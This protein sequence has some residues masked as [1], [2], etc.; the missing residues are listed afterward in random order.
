MEEEG[1]VVTIP[2]YSTKHDEGVK[3]GYTAYHIVINWKGSEW[4]TAVRYSTFRQLHDAVKRRFPSIRLPK[5]PPKK[6][7]GNAS[8]EFLE[9]RRAELETYLS[10]LLSV[11]IIRASEEVSRTLELSS[12]IDV[13]TLSPPATAPA[14]AP[15]S[16][17]RV[18]APASS[19]SAEPS[20]EHSTHTSSYDTSYKR[21]VALYDFD[22]D[23]SQNQMSFYV[24][25]VLYVLSQDDPEQT[26]WWWGE[27]E[28]GT[29]GYLPCD[30]I[31][32]EA[33]P[34]AP[35]QPASVPQHEDNQE[36]LSSPSLRS[37]RGGGNNG[38]VQPSPRA[39]TPLPSPSQ[40]RLH[41]AAAVAA[42]HTAKPAGA[43]IGAVGG[44]APVNVQ[45]PRLEVGNKKPPPPVPTRGSSFPSLPAVPGAG[46]GP[47]PST[48]PA[49][50]AHKFAH[51]LG[52]A[53]PHQPHQSASPA[54]GNKAPTGPRRMPAPPQ[55]GVSQEQLANRIREVGDGRPSPPRAPLG[56]PRPYQPGLPPSGAAG[57]HPM[58]AMR[59]AIPQRPRGDASAISPAN[60]SQDGTD[61][62]AGEGHHQ[63]PAS[64]AAA[65]PQATAA[66]KSHRRTMIATEILT[67]ERTYVEGLK[68]LIDEYK[69][70]MLKLTTEPNTAITDAVIKKIFSNLEI[71]KNLNQMFVN[72]LEKRMEA[73]DTD[74]TLVGDLFKGL[75]PYLKMY[76]DYSNNF[77]TATETCQQIRE[78]GL[79]TVVLDTVKPKCQ[80]LTIEALLITPIQRLPRYN[81]LIQDLLRNTAETHP[82]Y[83]NLADALKSTKEIADYINES[84]RQAEQSAK[85]RNLAT[86][87]EQFR[88]LLEAHRTLVAEGK[89]TL[90]ERK[91]KS[92]WML[93]LF[94]D[95]IVPAKLQ[96]GEIIPQLTV[97]LPLTW[98]HTDVKGVKEPAFEI[99]TPERTFVFVVA[100]PQ[101]RLN[102]ADMDNTRRHGTYSYSTG[103][104]FTGQ[105][106][107]GKRHGSGRLE[108]FNGNVYDGAWQED[109]RHGYGTLTYATGEVYE[110]TWANDKK[111]GQGTM[112]YMNGAGYTGQWKDGLRSGNGTI[113]FP[114]GDVFEGKFIGD[115]AHGK[116]KLR[117]HNGNTFE[118]FFED[119]RKHGLGTFKSAD[120]SRSYQGSWVNGRKEGSGL[121]AYGDGST[122]QGN[123]HDDKR[124]GQG[125]MT[126][127]DG[128]EYV[129]DWVKDVREGK[130]THATSY[131][132][133]YEG[134]WKEDKRN[135]HGT[136]VTK[137]GH[138]Y[139]GEWVNG[140]RQGKGTMV[141]GS[142]D[143]Y[144]GVWH[145]DRPHGNGLWTSAD[146]S[147]YEGKWTN[148]ARDGKCS[149]A[150]FVG[151]CKENT[152]IGHGDKVYELAPSMPD[153]NML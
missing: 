60:R 81:L 125:K 106:Q 92:Q 16:D 80:N 132:H 137:E 37:P 12:T 133:T 50:A 77:E 31:R 76:K 126:E 100:T 57:G 69:A 70:A 59:P 138:R 72:D 121:M 109:M 65:T 26:G 116:G 49:A 29:Q 143:K 75:A 150:A 53:P 24:D 84:I 39:M 104:E 5:L 56:G 47:S 73:W 96:R 68:W 18:S 40:E 45:R 112:K 46:G 93:C 66:E 35:P 28:D 8:E 99:I 119:D 98:L 33:E 97:P 44:P 21:A 67:T 129:G 58:P 48:S 82:D 13:A 87:G 14:P 19:S 63:R 89:V 54:A 120:G 147:K 43:P 148:G 36:K 23:A 108:Y 111:D 55:Y 25:E 88:R 78:N 32:F 140:R 62:G 30:Y 149:D 94:N 141:Y 7:M 151:T 90:A 51:S 153:L 113:A 2:T 142:G 79:V 20:S 145:Q 64:P 136:L 34:E 105:W 103:G 128:S 1:C 74:K 146:G 17:G 41:P 22:G 61:A 42:S 9:K 86:Q 6:L 107:L 10:E 131:G 15:S 95:I 52:N 152:V 110:G 123:W 130:G 85:F 3:D 91:S 11:P 122:Y 115:K 135:G 117:Y 38:L 124:H 114:N 71:I 4:R 134:Q 139:E 83:N 118:G 101:E 102:W 127:K 27:K 144:E